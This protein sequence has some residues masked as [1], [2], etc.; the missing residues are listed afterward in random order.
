MA[1]ADKNILIVVKT[2][3]SVIC[4]SQ[5][6]QN[7][8]S[9][10]NVTGDMAQLGRIKTVRMYAHC[11]N[12]RHMTNKLL[13]ILKHTFQSILTPLTTY[14]FGINNLVARP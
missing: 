6:P 3:K 12:L 5:S 8:T 7:G 4:T 13:W 1:A 9:D 10:A 2:P 14:S 11:T